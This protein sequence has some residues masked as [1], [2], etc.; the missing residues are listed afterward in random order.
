M[1]VYHGGCS[2][3]IGNVLNLLQN[4]RGKEKENRG[5]WEIGCSQEATPDCTP[6]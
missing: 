2:V 1:I 4:C 6:I 5:V 3:T